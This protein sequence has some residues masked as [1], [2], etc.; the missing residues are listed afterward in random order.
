MK[1]T[2]EVYGVSNEE[3]D[4]YI[5]RSEVDD[6][7]INGVSQNKHIIVFGSS[8]QG[9]TAL[10]NKH[11]KEDELLRINCVPE[12]RP[13]DIY[14]SILRQSRIEFEVEK[15]TQTSIGFDGKGGF[16][17]KV[18]IPLIADAQ[19]DAGGS[20]DKRTTKT[21]KSK[22]IEY[23]LELPQD[24]SE[25]LNSISFNKRIVLENFHYLDEETQRELAF[26]LRNFEDYNIL[27][28]ILGIWR[29]KNR[30]AQYN[31][32]LQDRLIEIP[33]EPW[34]SED[35]RRVAIE[36]E[37]LLNVSFN[38]IIENLIEGSFDSIGVFQELC[39]ETCFAA[40][41]IE[42][43]TDMVI[44]KKEHL[45]SAVN[46][47]MDD[48]SGRH[49]RSI[50]SFIEQKA[51]SSDKTPL[52]LAYYFVSI[53]LS[54]SFQDIVKG[55]RRKQ[56]QEKIQAIH[57]RPDDVRPSDMSNFL[58]NIKESQIKKRITPP[59]F[60]YDMSVRTLKVIDSTFYFFLRN[61]NCDELL[62]ELD[63]PE[64]I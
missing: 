25:I 29:E 47:K 31:G 32:D 19:V 38:D 21:T 58:H 15:S 48:Y 64:G 26:H 45:I 11:L 7:F 14:K 24:I 53:L 49:I 40:G 3:V 37:P 44:L 51:K 39:K 62:E 10:T 60:D 54:E 46:K 61:Y 35:F 2:I 8:K 12:S 52:Y 5:E 42:T 4:S 56:I 57:H 33:V 63:K 55:M 6:L 23:N 34:L 41:V 9:K 59:I 27:F 28:V 22:I 20:T 36:G 18:K 50:E 13:V 30:L 1:N 16:K 17:A 43:Q